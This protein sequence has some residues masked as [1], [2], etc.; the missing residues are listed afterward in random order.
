MPYFPQLL[1]HWLELKRSLISGWQ[2]ASRIYLKRRVALRRCGK[3]S[4]SRTLAAGTPCQ[5]C[6]HHAK[7]PEGCGAAHLCCNDLCA[8]VNGHQ[9][10]LH[11]LAHCSHEWPLQ[12]V[13]ARRPPVVLVPQ[14]HMQSTLHL[15]AWCCGRESAEV[16]A[17]ALLRAGSCLTGTPLTHVCQC[18]SKRA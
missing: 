14:R 18:T 3:S 10:Q 5:V 13:A 16:A 8:H 9:L 15:C 6:R 2:H 12:L 4:G 11:S 7:Q 17:S 1:S